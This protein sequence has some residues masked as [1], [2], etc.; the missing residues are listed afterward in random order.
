MK[1]F[2]LLTIIAFTILACKKKKENTDGIETPVETANGWELV[3]EMPEGA[4]EQN[5]LHFYTL[6]YVKM[7]GNVVDAVITKENP[8]FI[9]ILHTFRWQFDKSSMKTVR[10]KDIAWS[11]NGQDLAND[12]INLYKPLAS[13]SKGL[14]DNELIFSAVGGLGN[15]TDGII[16]ENRYQYYGNYTCELSGEKPFMFSKGI[17]NYKIGN[18]ARIF[19]S[20][21]YDIFYDSKFFNVAGG[22]NA[23][24]RLVTVALTKGTQ[25]EDTISL[26]ILESSNNLG[27]YPIIGGPDV[28]HPAIVKKTYNVNQF[29][30]GVNLGFDGNLSVQ[31]RYGDI[32]TFIVAYPTNDYGQ[33]FD[34]DIEN[35]TL[36]FVK[37]VPFSE[38]F[39]SMS[40]L[41]N[42]K[43]HFVQ[44]ETKSAKVWNGNTFYDVTFPTFKSGT[45]PCNSLYNDGYL[46]YLVRYTVDGTRKLYLYRKKID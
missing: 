30:P 4:M 31:Q 14:G 21:G 19:N 36:S 17:Q 37:T 35:Q 22:L 41:K 11:T 34:L 23:N 20:D 39:N 46:W 40:L 6:E 8:E 7:H 43:H 3:A 29:L 18:F 33:M 10:L 44:L 25:L 42:K 13:L 45:F 1:T 9:N 27:A 32:I 12:N 16:D 15:V 26:S 2:L 5:N 38:S 24:N 28:M